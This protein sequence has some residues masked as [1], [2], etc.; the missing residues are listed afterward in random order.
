[1]T[2]SQ[3]KNTKPLLFMISFFHDGLV[4]CTLTIKYIKL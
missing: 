3:K 1:M 4:S 2:R